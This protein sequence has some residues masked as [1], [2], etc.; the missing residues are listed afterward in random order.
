MKALQMIYFNYLKELDRVFVRLVAA[1]R[2]MEIPIGVL[3]CIISVYGF[4]MEY[5]NQ[6]DE[7][8]LAFVI[9]IGVASALF[10][11]YLGSMLL[12]ILADKILIVLLA[13]LFIPGFLVFLLT[14][15]LKKNTHEIRTE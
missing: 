5:L 8:R 13:A 3:F 9:L 7:F 4:E 1:F 11:Y 10:G 14:S 12:N 15:K 2:K 6:A